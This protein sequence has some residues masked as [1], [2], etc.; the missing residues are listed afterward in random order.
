MWG[1][2]SPTGRHRGLREYQV[3]GVTK[4]LIVLKRDN[5]ADKWKYAG[6]VHGIE[7]LGSGPLAGDKD[8]NIWM[9]TQA[10]V[11]YE[12][13]PVLDDKGNIDLEKTHA[14]IKKDGLGKG[15]GSQ[16][17]QIHGEPFFLTDSLFYRFDKKENRFYA[18]TT[19]GHLHAGSDE[20]DW[21]SED[22][23]GKVWMQ[24]GKQCLI[25]TPNGNGTYKIDSTSLLPISSEAIIQ[26]FVD[27]DGTC[28]IGTPNG[29]IRYDQNMKKS[30]A[31]HFP[32]YISSIWQEI[33]L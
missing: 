33:F 30:Y 28:W 1:C 24:Y 11:I 12:I 32:V 9:T 6:E 17:F 14:E 27:D 25:A 15:G 26:F 31:E 7:Q 29:L 2:G 22:K 21:A 19:F 4:G 8:G 3:Q 18:D 5:P 20:Y 10:N 23:Q 13:I 16:M